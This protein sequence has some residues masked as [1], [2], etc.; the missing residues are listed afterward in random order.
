M[1]FFL[2]LTMTLLFSINILSNDNDGFA[3][4]DFDLGGPDSLKEEPVKKKK[5]KIKHNK[6]T[7]FK[8]GKKQEEKR[9]FKKALNS[10]ES[11]CKLKKLEACEKVV[12]FYERGRSYLVKRDYKKAESFRKRSCNL[13]SVKS[14]ISLAELYQRGRGRIAKNEAQSLLFYKKACKLGDKNSC[15][16]K[17]KEA[18][19]K[20][21]MLKMKESCNAGR[22]SSC[23]K[24]SSKYRYEKDEKSRIKYLK[25]SCKLKYKWACKTLGELNLA[26]KKT[27]KDARGYFTKACEFK[28]ERSCNIIDV[29]NAK[30]KCNSGDALSCNKLAKTFTATKGFRRNY[31]KVVKYY[32]K[33]CKLKNK[34]SCKTLAEVY[35]NNYY[36]KE[37]EAAF[38]Y[39]KTCQLDSSDKE[40][41]RLAVIFSYYE[42]CKNKNA[43]SCDKIGTILDLGIE[44][45]A[46]IRGAERFFKKACDYGHK[47]ACKK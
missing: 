20:E 12:N 30:D 35:R 29:F 47:K 33:G 8:L 13:G 22:A 3:P 26:D 17:S 43:D 39:K 46:N 37:K 16:K 41:C 42:E 44:R 19:K 14:C 15:G 4:G 45:R 31:D 38:F 34:L 25:K 32:K 28:D 40:S 5:K 21:K 18:I 24:L 1:R 27:F 6:H 2:V 36:E 10:Y 23:Y 7:L 9:K 11:S